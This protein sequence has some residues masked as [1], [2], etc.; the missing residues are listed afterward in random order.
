LSQSPTFALLP[1]TIL[2]LE[3]NGLWPQFGVFNDWAFKWIA[4][5]ATN[6]IE[7]IDIFFIVL[8]N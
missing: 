4:N 6:K 1:L 3:A 5:E 8:K 2:V 7:K